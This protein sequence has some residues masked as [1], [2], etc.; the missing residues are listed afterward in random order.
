MHPSNYRG[1]SLI[2]TLAKVYDKILTQR[3]ELWYKPCPLQAGAQ[4]Q[5]GCTEQILTVRLLFDIAIKQKKPLYVALID[6]Q[7]AYDSISRQALLNRLASKG[8]GT[9]FLRA[10]ASSLNNT[11]IQ[12]GSTYTE[13]SKGI[14]QGAPSSCSF[15]VVVMDAVIEKLCSLP[16]DDWIK[17]LHC[18]CFMDDMAIVATSRDQ[19]QKKLEILSQSA[20]KIGMKLHPTKSQYMTTTRNDTGHFTVSKCA[21]HHTKSYAYLGCV[22][23]PESLQTQEQ[24]E[25]NQ[26]Q[27]QGL[28]FLAFIQQNQDAPYQLKQKVW[29]SALQSSILYSCESWMCNTDRWLSPFFY[30][31]LKH[32]LGVRPQTPNY[33]AYI[34]SGINHIQDVATQRQTNFLQKM[35]Q[36]PSYEET[37]LGIV[38]KLAQQSR[39]PAWQYMNNLSTNNK[40]A[41]VQLVREVVR[42]AISTR[43][44][45][46]KE[47]NNTLTTHEVYKIYNNNIQESHRKAFT[48]LRLGSHR[49]KVETGRWARLPIEQRLCR[50]C[51]CG[52]IQG[53]C[54]VLLKCMHI[55]HLRA[56]MQMPIETLIDLYERTDTTLVT[57]LC[58][59]TLETVNELNTRFFT[60]F[61]FK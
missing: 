7:K 32:L 20:E 53:E 44:N 49:L 12:I 6:F 21:I 48:Q 25:I 36:H 59:K 10:I 8:C 16:D 43:F 2:P 60:N 28:K 11:R 55:Q 47:I 57:E 61:F 56:N 42:N 1:I 22:I 27:C 9:T 13:T 34:E 41:Y 23:S 37:P 30:K 50:V 3:M 31:C 52:S 38:I 24:R 18:L 29:Q 4:R 40:G 17:G 39:P 33:L 35:R 45:N 54:H 46:Y 19:L 15:F 14:K 51:P 58:F 5:R 26:R